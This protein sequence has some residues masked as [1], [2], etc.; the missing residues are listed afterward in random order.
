MLV[1]AILGH[2]ILSFLHHHTHLSDMDFLVCLVLPLFLLGL[3]LVFMVTGYSVDSDGIVIHRLLWH[4]RIRRADIADVAT[5]LF[6]A[7]RTIGLCGIWGFC[8]RS[9]FAYSGGLGFHIVAA[10][11][12]TTDLSYLG[13]MGCLSSFHHPIQ[14]HLFEPSMIRK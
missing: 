10:S 5:P 7:G 12:Y 2:Y 8:G 3:G 9:G 1:S 14:K 13:V 11:S 6:L 4:R